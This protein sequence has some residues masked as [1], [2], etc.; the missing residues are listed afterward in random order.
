MTVCK[1]IKTECISRL[2]AYTKKDI[3]IYPKEVLKGFR[4]FEQKHK[5]CSINGGGG[6]VWSIKT[7]LPF[8]I[9]TFL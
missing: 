5:F 9:I 3:F 6:C 4:N 1:K 2:I 7:L 8:D